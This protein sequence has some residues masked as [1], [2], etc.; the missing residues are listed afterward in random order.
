VPDETFD[1]S[2]LFFP[3]FLAE[4]S[5]TMWAMMPVVSLIALKS[6]EPARVTL[7]W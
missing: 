2:G 1:S 5:L 6:F 7:S 3:A 4:Q